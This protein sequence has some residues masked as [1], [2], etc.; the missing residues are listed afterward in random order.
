[1][2]WSLA[3]L[4]VSRIVLLGLAPLAE[5]H[6]R[7]HFHD[8]RSRGYYW[9]SER[10]ER[11]F[12]EIT[13]NIY[14]D[15]WARSDSW[16]Y[17]DIAER[18]YYLEPGPGGYGTVACF[19]LYPILIRAAAFA[20]GGQVL[21]AGLAVSW[22]ATWASLVL[23]FRMA[24]FWRD[25][26]TARL[27]TLALVCFPSAFFLTTIFPQSLFLALSLAALLAADRGRFLVAGTFAALAGATRAE[28]VVLIPALAIAFWPHRKMPHL[29][30]AT[31]GLMLAPLGLI[32]YMTFLWVRFDDPLAFMGI[33]RQFGRELSNPVLTLLRPLRDHLFN[34]RHFLTYLVTA[35][36]VVAT[37]ARVPRPALAFGW[38]L[39]LLP[40]A[41][42]QYESIYR[43]QLT[44]FPV[45]LG[46]AAVRPRAL[47]WASIAA[48]GVVQVLMCF[49]FITGVRLN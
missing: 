16:Q 14:L 34:I 19:P 23:L 48:C 24:F 20:L 7:P 40:L 3:L 2:L 36:L 45:F 37:V 22:L 35:W 26:Q 39:F 12:Y 41:T 30:Q 38:L 44:T 9:H 21:I 8:D 4:V 31:G 33:H 1:M 10:R 32:A 15:M 42:G 29:V 43:V 28:G 25:M 11:P 5:L 47:A 13:P 18:G 49:P 27:A 17:L 46:M 6:K